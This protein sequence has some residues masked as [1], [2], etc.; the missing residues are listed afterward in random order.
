[1]VSVTRLFAC[2]CCDV[3][4]M[5]V[6]AHINYSANT[7]IRTVIFIYA[8]VVCTRESAI[9]KTFVCTQAHRA[10]SFLNVT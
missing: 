3:L 2:G 6:A 8:G 5:H 7:C 10:F 9:S 4:Q 1:M